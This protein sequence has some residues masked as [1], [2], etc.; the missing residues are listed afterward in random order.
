M[1]TDEPKAAGLFCDL[2]GAS[3]VLPEPGSENYQHS[4]NLQ[5]SHEHQGRQYPLDHRGQNA[6]GHRRADFEAQGG[7]HITAAAQGDGK[8]VGAVHSS[9]NHDEIGGETQHDVC[10]KECNE[11]NLCWVVYC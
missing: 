4:K 10:H 9:E 6:P 7:A 3:M 11:R 2:N 5:T 1:L 8:G